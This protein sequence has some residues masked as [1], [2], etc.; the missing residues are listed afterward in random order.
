MNLQRRELL[1]L[2]VSLGVG[3]LLP[4]SG[5]FRTLAAQAADHPERKRSCILLWLNGGPSTIDL[6]DLKPGHDNGGPS[7]EIVTTVPGLRISEHLPTLAQHASEL[8]I[9]RSMSTKEGDHTRASYLAR[10]GNVPRSDVHY[11]GVGALVAK[12]LA[13]QGSGLPGYVSIARPRAQA[14]SMG[15]TAGFLGPKF[16]PLSVGSEDGSLTDLEVPNLA[17]PKGLSEPE[18]AE[19]LGLLGELDRRFATTRKAEVMTAQREAVDLAVQMMHPDS[20]RA[21]DLSE[22]PNT[23]RDRYGRN[24]FGQGCLMARRLVE[25]G[26]P[27]VEVTLGGW[28]THNENFPAVARLSRTL[29]AG[30]GTLLDD[31]NR[32]GLLKSTLIVCM[33]EFGRTPRI[34]ARG[35][36]DHWPGAWSL[37]LAGAGINPGQVVGR[38]SPDGTKVEERPITAPDFLATICKALGIDHTKQNVSES[39]RPIR[40]VDK[41]AEVIEEIAS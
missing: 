38:T 26:V 23:L 18:F 24:V 4:S 30:F 31:L 35:G 37:A 32:L 14:E 11:P 1:R 27:F 17:R 33:G 16:S 7:R 20:A 10:T 28:D 40:I 6:W 8:A 25:R 12:E 2:G 9:I 21:F 19:R 34:N 13:R 3:S 15:Y 39:G 41:S 29:D 22:E 5:W 36:R